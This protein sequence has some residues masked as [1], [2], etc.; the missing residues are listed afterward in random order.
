MKTTLCGPLIELF[1]PSFSLNTP[2]RPHS[3]LPVVDA[4]N[5]G[6]DNELLLSAA[7]AAS[8]LILSH[9]V[10][11]PTAPN[12]GEFEHASLFLRKG[13]WFL[14]M[15]HC[16]TL[17]TCVPLDTECNHWLTSPK[18]KLCFPAGELSSRIYH[19]HIISYAHVNTHGRTHL[20][21]AYTNLK[22]C[23]VANWKCQFSRIHKT[24]MSNKS[25]KKN[26]VILCI[27]KHC[28]PWKPVSFVI[29]QLAAVL[30]CHSALG[31]K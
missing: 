25:H 24:V 2:P 19:C 12:P 23:M 18:F 27:E 10:V 20:W 15:Q 16:C 30:P 6:R 31:C 14:C 8:R 4:V 26:G 5:L 7:R 9:G 29:I 13:S 21:N 22:W 17:C 11:I 28:S 3:S 1:I